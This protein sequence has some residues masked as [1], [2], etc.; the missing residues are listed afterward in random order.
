MSGPKDIAPCEQRWDSAKTAHWYSTQRFR[1]RRSLER[2]LVQIQTLLDR[3]SIR[4]PLNVLDVPCGTGRLAPMLRG[5]AK[6]LVSADVA[7]PMLLQAR[8]TAPSGEVHIQADLRALPFD[9]ASFDLVVCCRVL[10][11]QNTTEELAA[12]AR[13]LARVSRGWI[14]ASFWDHASLPALRTRLGLKP[15]ETRRAVRRA[16][17]RRIVENNGA[18]VVSFRCAL[19]WISQQTFFAA[20]VSKEKRVHP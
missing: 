13:E 15:S 9:D 7:R 14:I 5:V 18:R 20:T 10:H 1:T 4:R 11:H 16:L 19:R 3:H 12:I 8:Q 6:R 17:V 2:D